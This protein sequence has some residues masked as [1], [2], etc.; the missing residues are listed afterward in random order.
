MRVGQG[1]TKASVDVFNMRCLL[2]FG[3]PD[4]NLIAIWMTV[5]QPIAI[6]QM[7]LQ[8]VANTDCHHNSPTVWVMVNAGI[9]VDECCKIRTNS[10]SGSATVNYE[11]T[12]V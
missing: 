11:D 4:C 10:Q 8:P 5:L 9:E 1:T 7:A 2:L 6:R 12:V 3:P